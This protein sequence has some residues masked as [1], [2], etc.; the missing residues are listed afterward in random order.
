MGAPTAAPLYYAMLLFGRFAQGN[1]GCGPVTV[2]RTPPRSRRWQVEGRR[3]AG[4][5]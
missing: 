2:S 5:S 4:C 3:S 1:G